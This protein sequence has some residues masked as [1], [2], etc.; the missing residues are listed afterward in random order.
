M[1]NATFSTEH[2]SAIRFGLTYFASQ[3]MGIKN[4]KM[5]DGS[6]RPIFCIMVENGPGQWSEIRV[7]PKARLGE[8][9]ALPKK[10]VDL[11]CTFGAYEQDNGELKY[12]Q[13]KYIGWID[14][15]TGEKTL[16]TGEEYAFEE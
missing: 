4:Y 11:L 14:P 5:K 3:V 15:A 10:P 2:I 8:G 12:G 7:W 6:T 9:Q 16:L 1:A 13:P